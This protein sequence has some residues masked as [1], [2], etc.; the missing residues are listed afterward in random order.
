MGRIRREVA[1]MRVICRLLMSVEVGRIHRLL[2]ATM[3]R[4]CGHQALLLLDLQDEVVAE[5]GSVAT[6]PRSR[7]L[8]VEGEVVVGVRGGREV[9]T[10][11]VGV[12]SVGG[13]EALLVYARILRGDVVPNVGAMVGGS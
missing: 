3:H 11:W 7:P 10:N 5:T 6:T 4:L 1:I 8:L 9:V 2:A 12:E 13:V